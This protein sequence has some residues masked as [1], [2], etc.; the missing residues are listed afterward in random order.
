MIRIKLEA[1][2]G[3]TSRYIPAPKG[4]KI[5]KEDIARKIYALLSPIRTGNVFNFSFPSLITSF[6]SNREVDRSILRKTKI[7]SKITARDIGLE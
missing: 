3:K 4:I 1:Y 6:I 2:E 7:I 5:K